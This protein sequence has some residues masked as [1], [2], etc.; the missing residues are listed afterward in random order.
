MRNEPDLIEMM[1]S[2]GV[3][4][5][6][7]NSLTID[8]TIA[9]FHAARLVVG[10]HGAGLGNIVFC[11]PGGTIYELHP[12]HSLLLSVTAGPNVLAQQH[13]LHYWADVHMSHGD[14][15]R[16]GHRVPWTAD[17]DLVRRRLD[18]IDRVHAPANEISR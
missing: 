11:R 9:K 1:V 18:E 7:A 2:R 3:D 4:V 5:V 13:G 15:R 10:A 8:E 16:F 12:A 17:L 6:A 14:F